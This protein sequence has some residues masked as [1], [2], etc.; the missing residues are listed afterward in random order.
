[1]IVVFCTPIVFSDRFKQFAV[2]FIVI[3]I[4][5]A[6]SATETNTHAKVKSSGE[7]GGQVS[8]SKALAVW[9]SLL[10][11]ICGTTLACRIP[12]GQTKPKGTP[13][14]MAYVVRPAISGATSIMLAAPTS[15]LL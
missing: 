9:L 6:I 7:M 1:M 8:S 5:L 15:A 14:H 13:Q 11:G 4:C 3:G 12:K 10:I 2:V